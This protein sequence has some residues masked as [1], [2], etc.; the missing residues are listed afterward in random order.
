MADLATTAPTSGA[1]MQPNATGTATSLLAYL[2]V[3]IR[4]ALRNPRYLALVIVFPLVIYL[5]ESGV[6]NRNAKFATTVNG[7]PWPVYTLVTTS[8]FSVIQSGLIWSRIVASD[9]VSG[10]TRLLRVLP[11]APA[12]YI[13][14]KLLVSLIATI[15]S[16]LVIGLSAYLVGH[17]DLAPTSWV[18]MAVVFCLGSLPFAAVGLLLGYLFDT[19]SVQIAYTAA[20]IIFAVLGGIVVPIS[21]FPDPLVTVA[22]LLPAYHLANIGWNVIAGNAPDVLDVLV[23][24]AYGAVFAGLV[25]W[26][27][28][29]EQVASTS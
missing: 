9:R 26:R 2:E 23:L 20:F 4:R 7:L 29:G 10:W 27:Y 3:E 11:L 19:D 16:L 8:V 17:A 15:P 28:R 5:L 6:V 12:S 18:A 1:T 24:L 14:S 21:I 25:V 13:G 22:Q